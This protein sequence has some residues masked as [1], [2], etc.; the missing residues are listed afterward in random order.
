MNNRGQPPPAY[1]ARRQRGNRHHAGAGQERSAPIV[2]TEDVGQDVID[3][4]VIRRYRESLERAL[5]RHAEAGRSGP[6]FLDP[7]DPGS[8]RFYLRA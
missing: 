4:G 3:D 7:A 2:P 5:Q 8:R 6:L 1:R